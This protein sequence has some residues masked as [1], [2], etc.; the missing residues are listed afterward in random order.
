[1]SG[2]VLHGL[3]KEF[4]GG[5]VAVDDLSL[6][7]EDGEFLALV[8]PSGCGKSTTLRLV[9]G[10][11]AV[12]GGRIEIGGRDVTD[13]PPRKRDIAMVF[14]NYALYP[15][16]TVARQHRLRA[17]HAPGTPKAEIAAP[18][19][20]GRG[21]ARHRPSCSTASRASSPAASAS[22]S[23]WAGRSCASPRCSC[24]TSR[25]RTSTRSC[26]S[27]CAPRSPTCS[28][29]L[30]TTDVYVTHDQIEAM[31]MGDRIAV[32]R[33]GV[34]QQV[35]PP[36][37]LYDRP[38]NRFVAGFI[39][40][41]A[42]NVLRARCSGDDGRVEVHVGASRLAVDAAA[43]SLREHVGRDVL[44]GI[45]PEDFVSV[46]G[47]GAAP[48]AALAITVSRSESSGSDLF[49]YFGVEGTTPDGPGRELT[50]RLDR[51]TTVDAG[52]QARLVVDT[53]R[54]YFFD[55]ESGAAIR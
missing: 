18:R 37:E 15:H 43:P 31:T 17:P 27:R 3:R 45:R 7:I 28:G 9:A 6:E 36:A 21:D 12:T 38:V 30:G 10:L 25:S 53:R 22:A 32:M 48:D 49:V 50:A 8:G 52:A 19:R 24:S 4:A 20:A 11:E 41:P 54:L 29:A 26:A 13:L 14:Q 44:V 39:G 34:L 47:D 40:S 1:M 35:G 42:M 51:G 5:V 23:P 16:M 2:I 55:P 46:A 33:D